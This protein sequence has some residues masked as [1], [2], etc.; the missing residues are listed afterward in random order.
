[1]HRSFSIHFLKK[2]LIFSLILAYYLLNSRVNNLQTSARIAGK[3]NNFY[4]KAFISFVKSRSKDFENNSIMDSGILANI[5]FS[6]NSN[7]L[8]L[9]GSPLHRSSKLIMSYLYGINSS[10]FILS[11]SFII[12]TNIS[13]LLSPEL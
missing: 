7:F 6:F 11:N 8:S 10:P 5:I 2:V 13:L 1:V 3:C 9:S 4:S 12:A